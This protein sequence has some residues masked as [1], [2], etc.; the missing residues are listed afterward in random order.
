MGIQFQRRQEARK[1]ASSSSSSDSS[2]KKKLEPQASPIY[3]ILFSL[4]LQP[5]EALP[6]PS[7]TMRKKKDKKKKKAEQQPAEPKGCMFRSL[8]VMTLHGSVNPLKNAASF[9]SVLLLRLICHSLG[10][11]KIRFDPK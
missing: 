6:T 1:N 7:V 11:Q 10:A 2:G 3:L 9:F 8:E 4:H 5:V